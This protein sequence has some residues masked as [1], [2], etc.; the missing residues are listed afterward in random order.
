MGHL[1]D[2]FRV[3]YKFGCNISTGPTDLDAFQFTNKNRMSEKFKLPLR[4]KFH[5]YIPVLQD[6]IDAQA[7]LMQNVS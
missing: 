4:A 6:S 1:N 2:V 3:P 5:V 7:E